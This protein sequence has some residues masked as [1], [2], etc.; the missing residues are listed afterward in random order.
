VTGER[1][2]AWVQGPEEAF[3][4]LA[5]L[6]KSD[7][8]QLESRLL[9]LI[10]RQKELEREI[11]AI[12]RRTQAGQADSLL[13]RVSDIGGVKVLVTVVPPTDAKG[14]R[15]MADRFRDRLGS[16]VVAIGCP[17]DGKANLLVAITKDL[18]GRLRAGDVVAAMA[19]EVGG[20][21]GGRPDLAQAGGP[22]PEALEAAMAKA[23]ALIAAALTN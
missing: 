20:R 6:V 14:L 4:R 7:R 9:R 12:E 11:E 13:E 23:A 3:D 5:G 2:V 21:G 19:A 1:A 8:A 17:C 22:H 16:G 10:E 18:T 15:E